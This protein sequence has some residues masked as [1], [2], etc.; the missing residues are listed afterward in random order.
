M[1]LAKSLKVEEAKETVLSSGYSALKA[2]VKETQNAA[3]LAAK[4]D[5]KAEEDLSSKLIKTTNQLA[6]DRKSG[7]TGSTSL[8]QIS[9]QLSDQERRLAAAK[10]A[11]AL[12]GEKQI[13]DEERTD[14]HIS[15][16]MVLARKENVQLT[17]DL[18]EITETIN[19]QQSSSQKRFAEELETVRNVYRLKLQIEQNATA[20][21][22]SK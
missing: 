11:A 22:A 21:A 2:E 1:P 14:S 12:K 17:L 9:K 18:E 15:Q 19:A 16:A 20:S 8:D 7:A 5:Q 6:A 3:L 13:E 10:I 4:S